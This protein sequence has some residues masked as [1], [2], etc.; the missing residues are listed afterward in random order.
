MPSFAK[1]VTGEL[2]IDWRRPCP[3]DRTSRPTSGWP[4]PRRSASRA[5][6]SMVST[7]PAPFVVLAIVPVRVAYGNPPTSTSASAT[8]VLEVVP[9]GRCVTSEAGP[10]QPHP[11][12][13]RRELYR[14]LGSSAASMR[15]IVPSLAVIS[16]VVAPPGQDKR[17]NGPRHGSSQCGTS[18]H[19]R[20]PWSR[21]PP[22]RSA[23]GCGCTAP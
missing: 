8:S 18:S 20:A 12:P 23:S 10:A 19:G 14:S 2:G 21:L 4:R 17:S 11:R 13:A 5:V 1:V 6:G 15:E 7:D 16:V 3:P 22:P 9:S